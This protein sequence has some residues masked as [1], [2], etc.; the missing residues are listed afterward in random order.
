[1]ILF[2][3]SFEREGKDRQRIEATKVSVTAVQFLLII[4]REHA[5]MLIFP[6]GCIFS[7]LKH[8]EHKACNTNNTASETDIHSKKQSPLSS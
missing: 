2:T 6:L 8:M 5:N 1:M 7:I 3:F 4:S